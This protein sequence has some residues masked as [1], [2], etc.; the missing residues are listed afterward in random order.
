MMHPF[1]TWSSGKFRCLPFKTMYR[2]QFSTGNQT[3][4]PKFYVLH[5]LVKSRKLMGNSTS[6]NFHLEVLQ[7]SLW[8]CLR[9]PKCTMEISG[10][11]LNKPR[12][13]LQAWCL[14]QLFGAWKC[15]SPRHQ[16]M[17]AMIKAC[18]FSYYLALLVGKKHT[19][20]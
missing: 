7:A 11:I 9:A 6:E 5:F 8:S 15:N 18:T 3:A 10:Q 16:K 2:I 20:V 4:S 13:E 19:R 14:D 1:H 12:K 17:C